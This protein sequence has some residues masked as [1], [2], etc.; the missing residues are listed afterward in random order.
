[1]KKKIAFVETSII[2]D[3]IDLQSEDKNKKGFI[4]I[5]GKSSRFINEGEQILVFDKNDNMFTIKQKIMN[6]LNKYDS[7]NFHYI[8]INKA[9]QYAM[10]H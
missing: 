6:S 2:G 3:P 9:C 1:M 10:K 7:H 5:D 8:E 4:F